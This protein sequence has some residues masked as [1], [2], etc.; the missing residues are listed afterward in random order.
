MIFVASQIFY[1]TGGLVPFYFM[2]AT[3]V[4]GY[5]MAFVT[6]HRPGLASKVAAI[7]M[8]LAAFYLFRYLGFTL[9][10]L[11]IA[12]GTEGIAFWFVSMAL[13]AGVSF[14]TFHILS[15]NI[16]VWDARIRPEK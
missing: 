3:I 6:V 5:L 14:Y 16:D 4:W 1:V 9:S 12:P 11:G 10:T 7:S 2:T 8:P 15:Y 13:P